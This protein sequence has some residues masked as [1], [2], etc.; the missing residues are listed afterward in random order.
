MGEEQFTNFM[1]RIVFVFVFLVAIKSVF[2]CNLYLHF[3]SLLSKQTG[4]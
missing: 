4:P 1:S 2:T 3:P